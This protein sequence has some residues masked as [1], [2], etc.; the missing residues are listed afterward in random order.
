[1][2]GK[3]EKLDVLGHGASGIVYLAK[4]T[5]L[6]RQV[7]IKVVSLQAGEMQHFLE[8]AR[9]LDRLKHPNIVRVHNVDRIDGNI[10]LD[11]EYVR[12]KNVQEMLREQ[13][14]LPMEYAL[15]IA[16]QTLDALQYAHE[17]QT[18][19]RDI[20]PA[21]ILISRQGE[22]KLVDFGLAEILA[23]NAYAGG[24][25]TY[26]YMAPEDFAEE[27]RSD[28]QSDIWAVGVTLYEMLAGQR[29]FLVSKPKDPFAWKRVLDNELPTPISVYV[30][31]ASADLQTIVNRALAR[32]KSR[33]Y[34][35][36]RAF[37][38]DLRRLQA[39]QSPSVVS[40]AVVPV[41]PPRR[42]GGNGVSSA[43]P[44]GTLRHRI[45]SQ[46][47]TVQPQNTMRGERLSAA[48]SAVTSL[49]ATTRMVAPAVKSGVISASPDRVDFGQVRTNG[50]CEARVQLRSSSAQPSTVGRVL[51]C[52]DWITAHPMMF[53]GAKQVITLTARGKEQSHPGD[54]EATVSVEIGTDRTDIPVTVQFVAAR[55][56]FVQ[57]SS[58]FVPVF[59]AVQLPIAALLYAST[60]SHGS[61]SMAPLVPAA[62]TASGLLTT[63][64]LLIAYAA[65][66]GLAERI[67]CGL[68]ILA[69]GAVLGV[70]SAHWQPGAFTSGMLQ[71]LLT[72]VPIGGMLFLQLLSLSKWKWWAFVA[73]CT[74]LA[75]GAAFLFQLK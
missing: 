7:A 72:G 61:Q 73:A 13:G 36:A 71:T 11:M 38:D 4:D 1:M 62:A 27:D 26:A 24:A 63:M 44:A 70:S 50:A 10:V 3:Y 41:S 19:H 9:V 65:D 39:G 23:T 15:E 58:W 37:H 55:P 51:D 43:A 59:A 5:L 20:K 17:M 16:A 14:A 25:G 57:I 22:V 21:N 12:G 66:I 60:G 28:H 31:A 2:L 40:H 67:A 54:R 68:E 46:T 32:D 30:P 33:R 18:V 48:A 69:M 52:P 35:T 49:D 74:G 8:E 47:A 34:Q 64:L 42:L 56:T 53:T 6:N 75:I 29:P 45:S